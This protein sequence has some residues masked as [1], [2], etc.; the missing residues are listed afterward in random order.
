MKT[1]AEYI[2]IWAKYL[3]VT[4]NPNDP[5]YS[6]YLPAATAAVPPNIHGFSV[7]NTDYPNGSDNG[8]NSNGWI[9]FGLLC[10]QN[11]ALF[12]QKRVPGDCG[13]PKKTGGLSA[14]AVTNA[15]ANL[16]NSLIQSI[17]KGVGAVPVIGGLATGL[18][19]LGDEIYNIIAGPDQQILKERAVLCPLSV[20]VTGYLQQIEQAIKAGQ[21]SPANGLSAAQTVLE[22]AKSALGAISQDPANTGRCYQAFCTAFENFYAAYFPTLAK[23]A[24]SG[25]NVALGAGVAVA[26]GAGAV[27]L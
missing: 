6:L 26:A 25:S 23:P 15:G 18:F 7:G 27:F 2:A 13:T 21:I 20:Q 16:A 17:T 11:R 8:N 3:G 14:L 12:Y 5:L 19:D 22:Q 10:L 4:W 1:V 9:A 24:A